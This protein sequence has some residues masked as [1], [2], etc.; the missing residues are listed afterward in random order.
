MNHRVYEKETYFDTVSQMTLIAVR[1][2]SLKRQGIY[3]ALR[4]KCPEFSSEYE[5]V[6]EFSEPDSPIGLMI[7]RRLTASHAASIIGVIV[8]RNS[9][10]ESDLFNAMGRTAW[11][12]A[13]YMYKNGCDSISIPTGP[14]FDG[15]VDW[16]DLATPLFMATN[17]LP[18]CVIE[19]FRLPLSRKVL[20]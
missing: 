2:N 18:F 3:Q 14:I 6:G 1:D 13:S 5:I 4:L 9:V 16:D 17:W 8:E 11:S 19:R 15:M 10:V 20:I 7:A 12:I